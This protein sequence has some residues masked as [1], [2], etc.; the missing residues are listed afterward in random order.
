MAAERKILKLVAPEVA[1]AA[2]QMIPRRFVGLDVHKRVV[3][4]CVMDGDGSVLHELRFELSRESVMTLATRIL[5]PN[6]EVVVEASTN[7]WA[8]VELLRPEVSRVVVSNPM[9]TRAIAM[10]KVK[11]D[12]IDA[13]VLANLLRG[14][15]IAEVWQPDGNTIELRRLTSRRARLISQRTAIKNRVQALLAERLIGVPVPRLFS[16]PGLKWLKG[17]QLDALGASSLASDLRLLEGIEIEIKALDHGLDMRGSEDPRLKILLTLPGV[18]VCAAQTLLSTLGDVTR[19]RDGDHAASYFGLCPSTKQSGDDCRHGPITKAGRSQAR[20]MMIQAA[21]SVFRHP[22]PLGAFARRLS[23]RKG[24]NIA[25]VATAR[26]LVI[27]AYHLLMKNEPYRYATPAA[28]SAKL[29]GLRIR[30]RGEKRKGGVAKGVDPRTLRADTY[31]TRVAP[32]DE[33]YT[34]EG[35]PERATPTDG[36]RRA[37]KHSGTEKFVASLDGEQFRPRAKAETK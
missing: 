17:L 3:Q 36:E 5:G 4:A 6:D 22:G 37:I 27:V 20:W 9:Q 29:A 33:V 26:K 32:L 2:R 18:D 16:P 10:A 31:L 19:F 15:Y 23:R 24:H 12:K 21:Q 1:A 11:T 28:T 30:A 13:R 25:V 14:G 34:R 7:T 35:L 8:V